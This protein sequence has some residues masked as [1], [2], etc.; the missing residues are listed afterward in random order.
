MAS[1]FH[2]EPM[3][4]AHADLKHL[5]NLTYFVHL[6]PML[7]LLCCFM[8]HRHPI[9]MPFYKKLR[10]SNSQLD[11]RRRPFAFLDGAFPLLPH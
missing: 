8:R 5:R 2:G 11:V 6:L 7:L 10:R 1:S 3:G 4:T 9:V